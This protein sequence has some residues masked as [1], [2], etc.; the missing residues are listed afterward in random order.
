MNSLSFLSIHIPHVSGQY[1][2]IQS[3][4]ILHESFITLQYVG[5]KS[6]Q[7]PFVSEKKIKCGGHDISYETFAWGKVER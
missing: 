3:P 5:Q 1:F 6:L 2:L 4:W 7:I